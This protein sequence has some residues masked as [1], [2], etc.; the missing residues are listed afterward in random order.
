VSTYPPATREDHDTFCTTEKWDLVRGA[1]GKPVTHHRTYE[2]PLHD[3]RILRT[4]ISRPINGS[5]Y[6]KS[7]WSHILRNQ[8]EVSARVFFDCAHG[9]I[10][11]DRGVPVAPEGALPLYILRELIDRVGLTP[12]EASG[13]SLQEAEKRIAR[14]W[15]A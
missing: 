15:L 6:G 5:E 7:L 8:L 3:G 12:E 2:L 4:R 14:H 1:T 11:P 9:G 10:L 13:F